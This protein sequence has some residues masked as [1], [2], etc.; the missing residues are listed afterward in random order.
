MLTVSSL[1]VPLLIGVGV[2]DLLHGLPINSNGAY[3]GNFFDLLT[4]FGCGN[5]ITLVMVC[6]LN[7]A[8]FLTL[9]TTGDV[10]ARAQGLVA[11]L[12]LP[13]IVVAAI[14]I[15]WTLVAYG[16]SAGAVVAQVIAVVAVLSVFVLFRSGR[17]L[18]AFVANVVAIAAVVAS[19]FMDLYPNVMVSSTSSAY[20][21]TVSGTASNTYALQVMTV[22]AVIFLPLVLAYQ[23]WNY[24][25]FR[26]RIGGKPKSEAGSASEP[27]TAAAPPPQN[28]SLRPSPRCLVRCSLIDRRIL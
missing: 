24:Y 28:P 11:K 27:G 17:Q 1:L 13:V 9:K 6:L 12:I 3:T 25:V 16:H 19:L 20:N 15:V 22:V 4:P 7:G 14:L 18:W 23:A 5:S 10:R 8:L 26:S 21:L 2:G